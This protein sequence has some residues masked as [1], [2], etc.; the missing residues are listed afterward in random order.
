MVTTNNI[1]GPKSLRSERAELKAKVD[2]VN[3]DA[4]DNWN[5]PAWRQEMAAEMTESLLE[6]FDHENLLSLMAEVEFAGFNDRVIIKEVRGLRA[7]WL[8]IGG[9]IEASTLKADVMEIGRDQIGF[10][11][12]ENEDKVM[13]NF[14]ETQATLVELG[15]RRMDAAVNQRALALFQEAIGSGHASYVSG[16]G[17]TIASINLAISEVKDESK[18]NEVTIVGRSTMTDQIVDGI[19]G[20]NNGAGFLPETNEQLLRRGVL[21]VYR[22]ARIVTLVNHKDA[23]DVSF[24]PANELYVVAKDASK[25]AF[26]GGIQTREW[27]EQDAWEWHFMARRLFGGAIVRP[28]RLRRILDTNLSA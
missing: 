18:T 23:D 21:G 22:G 1:E 14:A 13:T 7:H 15:G 5:D 17:L 16:A 10:Q 6:G 4:R 3:A 11:V 12:S 25:F 19:V 26:W 24:F 8:A 9:Y 27:S 2:A 28:E 20:A